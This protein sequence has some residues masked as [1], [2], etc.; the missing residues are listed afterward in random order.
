MNDIIL[1]EEQI[2]M[3]GTS[4]FTLRENPVFIP[5]LAIS[6]VDA[7]SEDWDEEVTT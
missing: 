7:I 1:H 4:T 3:S 6:S 5:I 2:Q